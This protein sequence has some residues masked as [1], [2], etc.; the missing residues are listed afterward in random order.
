MCIYPFVLFV[1]VILKCLHYPTL[2][3]NV[4]KGLIIKYWISLV[5]HL[6]Y[7]TYRIS[8]I[9]FILEK[10][11]LSQQSFVPTFHFMVIILLLIND[12]NDYFP[13]FCLL[14]AVGLMTTNECCL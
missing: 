13:M 14:N 7:T 2:L 6:N 3:T 10:Y 8:G 9:Q 4:L 12:F 1:T 11:K 5:F